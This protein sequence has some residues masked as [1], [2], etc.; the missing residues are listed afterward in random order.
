M[1]TTNMSI[2]LIYMD[3][4]WLFIFSMS[5]NLAYFTFPFT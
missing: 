4:A 1:L 5:V 2:S 3:N